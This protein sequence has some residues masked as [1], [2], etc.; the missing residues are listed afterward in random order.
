MKKPLQRMRRAFTLIELTIG[1]M[2]GMAVATMLMTLFNQHL[3]FLRIY[4]AQSFIT[5]EAPVISY[6][7]SRMV[8]KSDRFRLHNTVADALA[9]INPVT[10]N[11]RVLVLNFRLPDRAGQTDEMR[12]SILAFEGTAGQMRLNYYVVPPTGAPGAPQWSI[13]RRATDVRFALETGVLRM[14]LTG[15]NAEVI[16]YSG[17]M[18]Q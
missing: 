18:Q 13:T 5:E 16:T 8:G 12:A 14:R 2:V 15:P 9:G 11:A 4:N 7:V 3:S 10:T 6:Y 1:M 17:S